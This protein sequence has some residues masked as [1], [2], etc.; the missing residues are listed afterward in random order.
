[1]SQ[2][3]TKL[4]DRST[5][6]FILRQPPVTNLEGVWSPVS[7]DFLFEFFEAL[8]LS[9]L[10]IYYQDSWRT[11]QRKRAQVRRPGLRV[12]RKLSRL[13]PVEGWEWCKPLSRRVFHAG[14]DFVS[15][16]IIP[17]VIEEPF[18]RLDFILD[19]ASFFDQLHEVLVRDYSYEWVVC[20]CCGIHYREDHPKNW[21]TAQLWFD[22][23]WTLYS[24][25]RNKL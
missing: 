15:S 18:L 21:W 23:F 19:S 1:M 9:Q 8:E 24:L 25:V 13:L 11:P 5:L 6:Q 14:E 22:L 16:L 10:F 7:P 20:W 2:V 3:E 12:V 4:E 17:Y